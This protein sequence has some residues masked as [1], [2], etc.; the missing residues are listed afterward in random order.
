MA[1]E[2]MMTMAAW[3]T[4]FD[5]YFLER[6]ATITLP[7]E[8]GVQRPITASYHMPGREKDKDVDQKRPAIVF[9]QYDMVHDLARESS[10]TKLKVDP[11]E[12]DIGLK[13]APIPWRLYYEFR[14]LSDFREHGVLMEMQFLKMFPPRGC[15]QVLDPADG[16]TDAYDFFFVQSLPGDSYLQTNNG[17]ETTKR[18]FRKVFRY[19]VR[20]EADYA[21]VVN[22]KRVLERIFSTIQ[23]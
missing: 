14:I 13:D 15:I 1:G 2:G 11:T 22:Y 16:R 8:A 5:D 4:E 9:S 21:T 10:A 20:T 19:M 23:K 7:D 12:T 18:I 3:V 17:G 6:L